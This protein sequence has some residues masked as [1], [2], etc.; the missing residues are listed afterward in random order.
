MQARRDAIGGLRRRQ[1]EACRNCKP[2]LLANG[3]LP[4]FT[5]RTGPLHPQQVQAIHRA[6]CC[7][8]RLCILAIGKVRIPP[9]YLTVGSLGFVA[10]WMSRGGELL[11]CL[12][13]TWLGVCLQAILTIW[14]H[15]CHNKLWFSPAAITLGRQVAIAGTVAV[16][17]GIGVKLMH[18]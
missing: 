3:G 12:T 2:R 7:R 4:N 10:G 8:S 18:H 9:Q 16:V 15:A 14:K 5:W 1:N 6:P 13:C 11:I 17:G